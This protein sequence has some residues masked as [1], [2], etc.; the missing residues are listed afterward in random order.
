[1]AHA[2]HGAQPRCLG[3]RLPAAG[4]LLGCC[5]VR[6][7]VPGHACS[8]I[9]WVLKLCQ[10]LRLCHAKHRAACL[11]SRALQA[12]KK[13]GKL[14]GLHLCQAVGC[15]QAPRLISTHM[16]LTWEGETVDMGSAAG[17]GH[18]KEGARG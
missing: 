13:F 14:M 6:R 11:H 17:G 15:V 18:R 10:G 9:F 4:C 7:S 8:S 12:D 16:M 3:R 5:Q 2:A 1:M